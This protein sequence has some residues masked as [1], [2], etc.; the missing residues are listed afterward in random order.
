MEGFVIIGKVLDTFGLE[1]ELKVRP[2]MPLEFF[3]GLGRIY[4]KRK[5]GDYVPFELEWI[6]FMNDKV[7]LKF[8]GYDSIDAVRQFKGAKV[9]LPEEDLPCLEEDEFYAYE[10]VGMEIE[11]DKGKKLGKVIRVQ[12]MGPYD[13]LVVEDEKIVIP[14]VSDIVLEVDKKKKK[15]IIKEELIPF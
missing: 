5:G 8:K 10:L 13:V 1:G 7:I 11:T 9:Y 2:Y 15:V 3:E 12:D 4:L 14:F 6:D